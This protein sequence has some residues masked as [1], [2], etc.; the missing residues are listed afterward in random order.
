MILSGLR[1]FDI[2]DPHHPKEIAYFNAPIPDRDVVDPSNFAMSAP[3]FA[4]ER[5]EIWYSDGFS[6]FYAVKVTNDVWP[7]AAEP[8]ARPPAPD[9]EPRRRRAEPSAAGALPGHRGAR[10]RRCSWSRRRSARSCSLWAL[11]GSRPDDEWRDSRWRHRATRRLAIVG[12]VLAAGAVTAAVLARR[13][14][15]RASV[16]GAVARAA[17]GPTAGRARRPTAP[18][19]AVSVAGPADGPT[20]VLAHCW[21][22]LRTFWAAVARDLVDDGHRVVVYDQRGHGAV[23]PRRHRAVDRQPRRRPAGRPRRRRCPR[24]RPRRPLDGRHDDPVLRRRA[25]RRL[26][27]SGCAAS[28]SWPPRRRTLGRALPPD[29][30]RAVPRRGAGRVDPTRRGRPADGARRHRR[31]SAADATST[32]PSRGSPPPPARRAPGSSSPWRPWTSAPP[33]PSSARCPTRVLVGTRDTLTPVR[34]RPPAGRRHPRR[35]ARGDP[36]RRAHAPARGPRAHRRRGRARSP[37]ARGRVDRASALAVRAGPP[38]AAKPGDE[39]RRS[40]GRPAPR[41]RATRSPATTPPTPG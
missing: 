31:A 39:H 34:G 19:L 18:H 17:R 29:A 20:V 40:A 4:P 30:R 9:A 5:G 2:R 27:S 10:C 38:A 3:A 41:D 28:C 26:R 6:G 21:T 24:R 25:P 1:V 7:F 32:S 12:G 36:G 11:R 37:R 35:R 8:G 13:R 22:G 16:R 14:R 15:R 33:A 23:D